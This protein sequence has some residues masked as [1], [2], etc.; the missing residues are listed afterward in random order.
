MAKIVR[1]ISHRHSPHQVF[2]DFCEAAALS[3][4]NAVDLPGRDAREVRYKE[5]IKRYEKPEYDRFPLMLATLAEGMQDNTFD[6]MGELFHELELHNT[7]KG[8]FFTP[9]AL[10]EGM[11]RMTV[12]DAALSYIEE[13]AHYYT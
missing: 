13:R 5:V 2:S 8:Q 10:C 4:R 6:Y 3:F 11:A 9:F 7:Y 1:D 12:D